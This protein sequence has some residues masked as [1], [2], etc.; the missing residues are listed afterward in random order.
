V[1]WGCYANDLELRYPPHDNN[2]PPDNA[3]RKKLRWVVS[4]C[5][6]LSLLISTYQWRRSRFVE[7]AD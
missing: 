1:K 4:P 2:R 7:V 3:Y 6:A 5:G